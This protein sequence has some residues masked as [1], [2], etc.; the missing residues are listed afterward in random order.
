M[1]RAHQRVLSEFFSLPTQQVA[2]LC[3]HMVRLMP[4]GERLSGV[5]V[6]VE[7]Y[8]DEGD[9]ASHSGAV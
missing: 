1:P 9:M 6:E 5:I 3:R 2:S 4:D 8:L 7:A